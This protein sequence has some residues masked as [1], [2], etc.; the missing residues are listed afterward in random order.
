MELE[1]SALEALAQDDQLP[2][3]YPLGPIVDLNPKNEGDAGGP[4]GNKERNMQW[5]DDQP[6]KS[7]VFLCFGS[8]GSFSEE[9]I[10]LIA[11]GLEQSGHRFLWALRR[12]TI[13]GVKQ[14]LT[15]D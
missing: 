4:Q 12:P 5:L 11:H 9:Q 6:P 8:G 1:S 2:P 7:V 10:M 3:T 13:D 15:R 14:G